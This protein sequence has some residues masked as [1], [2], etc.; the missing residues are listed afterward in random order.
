MDEFNAG[1]S[2]PLIQP[3]YLNK[4][5]KYTNSGKTSFVYYEELVHFLMLSLIIIIIGVIEVVECE[6][7]GLD[8]EDNNENIEKEN[9]SLVDDGKRKKRNDLNNNNNQ[10]IISADSTPPS[11]LQLAKPTDW[12]Q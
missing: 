3:K 1:A 11:S 4:K 7:K 6:I 10:E 5:K 8:R 2:F 12:I 9:D